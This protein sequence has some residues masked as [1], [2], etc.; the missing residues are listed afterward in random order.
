MPK[1]AQESLNLESGPIVRVAWFDLGERPG[2]LLMVVHHLAVDA[3][4]VAD[5][6]GGFLAR[7]R[8]TLGGKSWPCRQDLFAAAVGARL[9]DLARSPEARD[10]LPY[11]L[12]AAEGT[13]G[14]CH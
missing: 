10:E 14:A 13:P 11:W 12:A 7:L 1:L 9:G 8:P 5:P 3:V 6:D 2:R 4:V